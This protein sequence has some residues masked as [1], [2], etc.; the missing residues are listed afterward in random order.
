MLPA[1]RPVALLRVDACGILPPAYDYY[2]NYCSSCYDYDCYD[3]DC[4][5][6]PAITYDCVSPD[7]GCILC[8]AYY[9]ALP[10]AW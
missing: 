4:W 3:Y 8:G 10:H 5:W 7:G 1:R 9:C 6:A 2:H